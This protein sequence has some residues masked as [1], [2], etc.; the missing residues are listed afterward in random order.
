MPHIHDKIDYCVEVFIVHKNKVL[1]R[2]HDK[3]NIWLS[4]GG[5]IEL[6]EDPI[7]AAYREVKEEVGLEVKIVGEAHGPKNGEA[8]NRGYKYLIPPRYLGRHPVNENHEHIAFVYFATADTDQ[9]TDS[10]NEHERTHT[11]WVNTEELEKMELIPNVRF[12]A[13]EALK[14]LGK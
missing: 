4:V 14:E 1:L 10:T 12:Y 5:H 2:M 8:E 9:I 7:E 6:D 3:Y 13:T 11:R